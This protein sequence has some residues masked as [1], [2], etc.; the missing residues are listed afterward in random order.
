MSEVTIDD[1]P[2]EIIIQIFQNLYLT[3]VINNCS[4]TCRKWES[5]AAK[6]FLLPHFR[7]LAK[8]DQHFER[9]LESNFEGFNW[10]CGE[11]FLNENNQNVVMKVYEKLR[12]YKGIIIK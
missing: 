1:L 2:T 5:I 6:Y 10:R 8:F 7:K 12:I 11:E 3:D 9:T 4:A